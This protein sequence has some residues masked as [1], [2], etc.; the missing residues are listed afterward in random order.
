M[1]NFINKT[2][3]LIVGLTISFIIGIILFTVG[4]FIAMDLHLID[5]SLFYILLTYVLA[6]LFFV[7]GTYIWIKKPSF[8]KLLVYL[9]SATILYSVGKSYSNKM[10]KPFMQAKGYESESAELFNRWLGKEPTRE[11]INEYKNDTLA[12]I[13]NL[14]KAKDL[15]FTYEPAIQKRYQDLYDLRKNTYEYDEKLRSGEIK[16]TTEEIET[17]VA[18]YQRKM[19]ELSMPTLGPFWMNLYSVEY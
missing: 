15:N 4:E 12:G 6:F 10:I 16:V 14:N 9:I 5:G 13:E 8:K 1:K 18:D 7:V 19:D 2:F 3:K 11:N 17:M